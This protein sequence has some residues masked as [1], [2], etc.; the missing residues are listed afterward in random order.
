M[1]ETLLR[2]VYDRLDHDGV[3]DEPW[4]E[5]VMAACEGAV[6]VEAVL[7][8]QHGAAP[9]PAPAVATGDPPS[10][11]LSSISVTGFRG[12][13]QQATLALSAGPGLTLVVGRNGSGKSSFAEALELLL[14]G[15]N[16][17]WT[18][19]SKAWSEGWRNLHTGDVCD[20]EA[21]LSVEGV[22]KTTVRRVWKGD[23]DLADGEAVVQPHGKPRTTLDAVGWAQVLGT[24]RPFLSYNELGSTLDEGPSKLYDALA[25]V[26]GLEDLV[27]AD[28]ALV[29]ARRSR[30][31]VVR[32]VKELAGALQTRIRTLT[33][34]SPD[35]RLSDALAL[36]GSRRPDLDALEELTDGSGAGEPDDAIKLLKECAAIV[37]PAP[38]RVA[39]AASSLDEAAV[40][41]SGFAGTEAERAGELADL[42]QTAL[43]Y[44]EKHTETDCPVCGREVALGT[45]WQKATATEVDRLRGLA[46]QCQEAEQGLARALK[47]ARSLLAPI[48]PPFITKLEAVG[49]EGVVL[50]RAWDAWCEGAKVDAA[51]ALADHLRD[52]FTAL[53][54]AANELVDRAR[55]ELARREDQWRPVARELTAWL[56]DA[57]ASEAGKSQARLIKSAEDW[58]KQTAD[59]IRAD[60]FAPIADETKAVWAK[61]RHRS[62]VDLKAVVLSGAKISRRVDLEVTVDGVE[63]GALGVMSQGELHALALSLFLPRAMLAESP[64]R[65]VV[66]D[67][68]VQSMDPARVDGLARVLADAAR[69]RQVV[70]F[71]HDDRL[72]ASVRRMQVEA[73]VIAV[74]RRPGSVVECRPSRNPIQAHLDDAY[75]LAKDTGLPVA[76]QARVIPGLCRS[77]LEACFVEV[78]WRRRLDGGQAH[79]DVE[80]E[81]A[82]AGTLNKRAALALFDDVERAGDV[83]KRLNKLGDWAGTT[84]KQC[85][86]GAHDGFDGDLLDLVKRSGHL[87]DQLRNLR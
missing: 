70:V 80:D 48:A 51:E 46:R 18:D 40:T 52:R 37:V 74:T 20:I 68:P 38:D 39:T 22:G 45:S 56:V 27:E 63:G 8:E 82:S 49:L 13:G 28:T 4:A 34:G 41:R 73:T 36:L 53:E 26:L 7:D 77:A 87:I 55:A 44:H 61:L 72:P 32:Q 78:V 42:L 75:A 15:E 2:L 76:A 86:K 47:D 69:T 6:A 57:R 50:A 83:M 81:L 79:I 84:F 10:V 30:Q 43:S 64:F 71:T 1:N 16:K 85:N 59:G 24:Y 23:A 5:L 33:D 21:S 11:F 67:D 54:A 62:N 31:K 14:T 25:L 17:R 58:L 9:L 66:I 35:G 65:F 12:V 60:R 19:R 3:V 29:T